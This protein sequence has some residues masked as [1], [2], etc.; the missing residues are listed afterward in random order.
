MKLVFVWAYS[1]RAQ[2]VNLGWW[3]AQNYVAGQ[4]PKKNAFNIYKHVAEAD[5]PRT[6]LGA[7]SERLQVLSRS[8]VLEGSKGKNSRARNG[9]AVDG[10]DADDV[11]LDY[12][13]FFKEYRFLEVDDE[14]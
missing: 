3:Q 2:Y 8:D 6:L 5:S 13:H 12:L 7:L 11:Y 14:R 9:W 1:L 4:S 10:R